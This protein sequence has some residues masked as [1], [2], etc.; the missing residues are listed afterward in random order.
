MFEGKFYP[1][2]FSD[3][4][5]RAAVG[6]EDPIEIPPN[7]LRIATRLH[8]LRDARFSNFNSA[9]F[10]EPAWNMLLSLYIAQGRGMSLKISEVCAEAK[11][12]ATTALRW[13]DHLEGDGYV[14]RR[15]NPFHLKSALMVLTKKAAVE[16]NRYFA[17]V[18]DILY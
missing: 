10:G 15:R 7:L 13:L 1:T 11:V 6:S 4:P 18:H 9:Y 2:D 8:A 17:Q 5:I 16:L 3:A 14:A 12:P